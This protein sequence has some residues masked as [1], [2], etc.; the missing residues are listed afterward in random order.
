MG[1]GSKRLNYKT[2]ILVSGLL[3]LLYALLFRP[4]T[5]EGQGDFPA[6][7]DLAK[8]IF[9]LPGATDVDLSHRSP[10][11]SIIL[12]LFI[13]VFGEAHYLVPLIF[14]QYL[15]IFISSLL[16]YKI[17]FQLRGNNVVSFIAAL[18]G[19]L[20]L[21]TI[22]YGYM[23][24]TETLALFLFTLTVWHLVRYFNGNSRWQLVLS[25]GALGLLILTR[26]NML[27]LPLVA[28]VLLLAVPV[29]EKKRVRLSKVFSDLGIFVFAILFIV[30]IW[31][32]RNHFSYGRYELIPKHHVG[33]RWAV[34]AT[35]SPDNVVSDEYHGIF[36]IFLK[37]REEL[38]TG[39]ATRRYRKS[40]LL[41]YSG[42][43]RI[44]DYFRPAISGYLL[45]RNS[46]DELLRYYGLAKTPEGIRSL[47][48]KLVPF[49]REI[50]VQNKGEIRKFRVYSLL[51]S[52]KHI[53][54]TLT[55]DKPGNLNRLPSFILQAYKVLFIL[56]MVLTFTGSIVHTVYLLR[57]KER[58]VQG[59]R[60][61]VLYAFI[62]YFPFINWYAN[63]LGDAN[64]F[65]YPADTLIIGLSFALFS[66]IY[67]VLI[68]SRGRHFR[69][70]T[71]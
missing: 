2:F 5:F 18:A 46:E 31:A 1:P 48:E 40:S 33:Q 57:R 55:G 51:Y 69:Q 47:N 49:Y 26:Y 6:Y 64:R 53:S 35:I 67:E 66:W 3:C 25:G 28:V 24:L 15:L 14:F 23:V 50:A 38:I 10:L 45:Y 39:T 43:K 71:S 52:F 54:P 11:Y 12:G 44:N 36:E 13:L 9:G 34:P 37:E 7:L 60:W 21:T 29:I 42:I 68:I 61:I 63:V 32:L 20:N 62:W 8:Q 59:L 27:G 58:L 56:M 4:I 65:R 22:F 19:I 17:I 30:N 70:R 41:A 16:V